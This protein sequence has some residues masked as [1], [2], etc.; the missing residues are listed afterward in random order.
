[1]LNL[2]QDE[3]AYVLMKG[4]PDDTGRQRYYLSSVV[5][6]GLVT[7]PLLWSRVAA[8]AMRISQSVL[9]AEEADVHCFVDDPLI[10]SIADSVIQNSSTLS[11]LYYALVWL[12]LGLQISWKKVSKGKSLRSGF[13]LASWTMMLPVCRSSWL[14]QRYKNCWILSMS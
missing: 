2:R 13:S 7:G 14:R 9:K 3:R 5:V 12:R 1:M 11:I 10:V 8:A 4:L 6:F